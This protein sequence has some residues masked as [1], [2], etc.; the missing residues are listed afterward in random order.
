MPIYCAEDSVDV[1]SD[2]KQFRL[3]LVGGCPPDSYAD[4]GQL[5]GNPTYDWDFMEKRFIFMVD[6]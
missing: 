5:W 1:W 2:K 3:D 4:G 6:K